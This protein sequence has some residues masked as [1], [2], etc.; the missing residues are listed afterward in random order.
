[1]K[2]LSP[3]SETKVTDDDME[4]HHDDPNYPPL[5]TMPP[6]SI[7]ASHFYHHSNSLIR[8]NAVSAL[9]NTSS[10]KTKSSFSYMLSQCFFAK[11]GSKTTAISFG[12][13]NAHAPIPKDLRHIY[14]AK[15]RAVMTPVT[16]VVGDMNKFEED[17]AVFDCI[18]KQPMH[19]FIEPT[20]ETF[21]SFPHDTKPTTGELWRSS[22]DSV[23]VDT[24]QCTAG[25]EIVSTE[26]APRAS[27]HF[28][29][30]AAITKTKK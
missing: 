16:I 7:P 22:L 5:P 20:M 2:P 12:V 17:M 6:L 23:I 24:R 27:D 21:V 14:W 30:L 10:I 19:D 8:S 3:R 15:I 26:K 29:I 11:V 18:F 28:L 1:M 4:Y 25:V 9:T 13:V